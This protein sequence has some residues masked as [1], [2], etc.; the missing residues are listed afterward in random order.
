YVAHWLA[1]LAI[2]SIGLFVVIVFARVVL[3][4][5]DWGVALGAPESI[6]SNELAASGHLFWTSFVGWL[7]HAWIYSYFWSAASIIYLIL[8]RDVDGTAWHDVYLPE[9][10][11]ETFAGDMGAEVPKEAPKTTEVEVG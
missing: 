3:A 1:S 10:G 4:L 5:A 9:H 11:A 6:P 8:R 2:G 7:V